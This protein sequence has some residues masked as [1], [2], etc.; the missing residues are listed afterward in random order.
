MMLG[1]IGRIGR[2][3]RIGF[4]LFG[5]FAAPASAQVR[6]SEPASIAQTVDGTKLTV[7]YSRPRGR[8]RDSLFGKLVKWNEVWTPGANAA[9]TL[10]L[11]KDIKLSGHPIPK[12]KYS[13]W[14]V[15]RSSGDWTFV[16]DPRSDLFHEAHPDSTDKQIRFPI[17]PL[18]RP[19]TEVLTWSFP[20]VR[21]NGT[22]LAMHW[23]T[24]YVPLEVEVEPS[25]KVGFPE[26]QS[27]PDLGTY[28]YS[29]N[30]SPK[31]EGFIVWYEKGTLMGR[32]DPIPYPEWARFAL[33]PIKSDW[34]IPA[35][36]DDEG[37]IFEVTKELLFEFKVEGGKA[38]GL[39]VRG[40]DDKVMATAKRKG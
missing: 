24:V 14:M 33:I 22:T 19:F 26:G 20:E 30:G 12:G 34:F 37:R 1:R 31:K 23:G 3:G 18:E 36:L 11:N 7:T 28:E 21:V 40:E 35:F 5:L 25:Y 6:A 32:W 2:T 4:A 10:E 27:A 15:V 9:T 39:N 38:T 16:L 29:W 8:S 17:R 13:V